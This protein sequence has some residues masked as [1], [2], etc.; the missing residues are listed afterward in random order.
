MANVTPTIIDYGKRM[1][2]AGFADKSF[3]EQWFGDTEEYIK[4]DF[5]EAGAI[6]IMQIALDEL[7]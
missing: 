2:D 5:Q 6:R 1:L 7:S 3:I 4:L